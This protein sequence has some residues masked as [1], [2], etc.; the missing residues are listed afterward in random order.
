MTARNGRWAATAAALLLVLTGCAGDPPAPGFAVSYMYSEFADLAEARFLQDRKIPEEVAADLN[1]YLALPHRVT[2][3]AL[4]CAGEGS[5]YFADQHRI[6][7]C[8]DD[9]AEQRE[10]F[11]R[12]GSRNA[13]EDVAELVREILH[14]EAG[15]ALRDALNLPDAGDR[16]EEDAAD[17]FARLMLLR[18]GRPEGEATLLT[19][20]RAYD[21]EAAADPTPDPTDEHAPPATRAESHRCATY[22]AAPSRHPDLATPSRAHCAAD[23]A[24]TRDGWLNNLARLLRA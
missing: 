15:H 11:E 19:A 17:A 13:D 14:H 23:W 10:A 21:L 18:T 1:A 6:E 8:Y 9:L 12:A 22:G 5:A 16:A 2:V 3:V 24:A 7:L 4:S 20:A